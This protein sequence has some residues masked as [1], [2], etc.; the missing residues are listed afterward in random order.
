[1]ITRFNRPL[2]LILILI[3]V[4]CNQVASEP[5]ES[6]PNVATTAIG[7]LVSAVSR[8]KSPGSML[9]PLEIAKVQHRS[10]TATPAASVAPLSSDPVEPPKQIA[11]GLDDPTVLPDLEEGDTWVLTGPAISEGTTLDKKPYL[12]GQAVSISLTFHMEDSGVR[13]KW[14]FQDEDGA[15]LDSYGNLIDWSPHLLSDGNPALI[16]DW[17]CHKNAWLTGGIPSFSYYAR[18][19]AVDER[20]LDSGMKIVLF[21]LDTTFYS[22]DEDLVRNKDVVYGYDKVTGRVV[23]MDEYEH[24]ALDGVLFSLMQNLE[25]DVDH[26]VSSHRT[27]TA[28]ENPTPTPTRTPAP[29]TPVVTP[30]PQAGEEITPTPASSVTDKAPPVDASPETTLTLED[31]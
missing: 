20:T 4:A 10:A 13:Q 25:M 8:D 15:E 5:V 29:A 12:L 17:D 2:V 28:I 27:P 7:P 23:V 9:S 14:S 21:S 11:C 6:P 31:F 19:Y 24:R 1:M 18:D 16:L 3:L 26:V 30:H 22:S